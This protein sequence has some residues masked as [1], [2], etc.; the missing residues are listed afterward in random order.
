VAKLGAR[1]LTVGVASAVALVSGTHTLHAQGLI[2]GSTGTAGPRFEQVAADVMISQL[3]GTQ[4]LRLG[5][6]VLD[7]ERNRFVLNAGPVSTELHQTGGGSV[8]I[9]AEVLRASLGANPDGTVYTRFDLRAGGFDIVLELS[10]PAGPGLL[11]TSAVKDWFDES[12]W[13]VQVSDRV[14]GGVM[15]RDGVIPAGAR[16]A[17]APRPTPVVGAARF[18]ITAQTYETST[19]LDAAC[20]QEF[21]DAWVLADWNAVRA[22]RAAGADAPVP[23]TIGSAWVKRG[24]TRRAAANR[25]YIAS[26]VIHAGYLAHDQIDGWLWLGSWYGN[27]HALCAPR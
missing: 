25:F 8:Q 12:R 19:D 9:D 20:R 17:G 22:S 11:L 4:S 10:G 27:Y 3:I 24:G 7:G 13:R 5:P 26:S 21:G 23:R 6:L 1:W 14:S 15:A 2:T 18:Q 16:P